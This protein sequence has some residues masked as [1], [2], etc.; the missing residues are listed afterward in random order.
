[1]PAAVPDHAAMDSFE[2]RLRAA[3]QAALRYPA[4]ARMMSVTGQAQV[5]FRW[6][7]GVPSALQ[8]V[9]SAGMAALDDAAIAAVR[10]AAYPE[11]PENLEHHT[12]NLVVKVNF[13]LEDSNN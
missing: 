8:V 3:V 11:P 6:C 4:A 1:M 2:G 10:T 9:S 5:G 7:D 13:K 12:L